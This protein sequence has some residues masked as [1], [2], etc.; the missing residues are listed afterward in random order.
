MAPSAEPAAELSHL[1]KADGSATFSYAGYAVI[2]AV[3]GPVEA[4]RR[5]ENAFE[6]LVD[7]IVRPAAGVGGTRE[8]QLE[9]IMQ[10]AL[11]QLIPVRD[12]PRCVIQITL[13]VAETPENAYVNAKLVQAQ[14]NL[15]IIPA[16]LHT[17]ILGLLTAAIPLKTIAAATL[18][19]IPEEEGKD[20]IVDPTAVDI[21]HAKSV[22]VLA[23]TS[24]ETLLLSESEGAFSPDEWAKVLELGQRICC[25]HQKPGF[26][27]AMSGDDV[28][29]K[30]I[31]Q[32]IRS[33]MEA[34]VAEDLYWK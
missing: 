16:L 2:A 21:D 12:Y 26:D 30:S 33:A 1:A 14:L 18:L 19:A 6:A 9:K 7:V 5:D 22:H 20:V 3:N 13:Q 4:Q 8:R 28:E 11:R 27:T 17:A 29:S 24:P 25:E 23:F 32:F 34:K 10:A 31:R 15:P